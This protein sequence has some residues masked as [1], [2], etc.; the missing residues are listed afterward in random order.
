MTLASG[1]A[2][3]WTVEASGLGFLEGPAVMPDGSVCF[4]D[5]THAVVRRTSA[6]RATEVV[7]TVP[8]SFN[9][10]ALG[11]DGALYAADNGGMRPGLAG[12]WGPVGSGDGHV[13]RVDSEGAVSR[14]ADAL[15]GPGPHRLNDLCF[16][17][18]GR[19]WVTDSGNW[20]AMFDEAGGPYRGGAIFV[21]DPDGSSTRVAEVADFPNGIAPRLDASGLIVAHTITSSLWVYPFSDDGLGTAELFVDLSGI[22]QFAPDGLAVLDDGSVV[23]AGNHADSVAV[24][25]PDGTVVDLL[26]TPFGWGPTNLAVAPGRLWVT[27]GSGGRLCSLDVPWDP[28]V[29]V[30]GLA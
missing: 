7:C 19:L 11:P 17:R 27:M 8:G 4:S 20:D 12:G 15:A 9:A 26:S 5:Q 14:W 22:A 13:A 2:V 30:P 10:V 1:R 23:V 29:V 16:D 28:A 6:N 3:D 25:S 18:A 24:V 21:C